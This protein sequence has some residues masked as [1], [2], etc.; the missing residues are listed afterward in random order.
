MADEWFYTQQGQ[1]Q[2]PVSAGQLKQLAISGR[3]LPTD[4]VWKEGMANWVPASSTRGLFPQSPASGAAAPA[5]ARAARSGSGPTSAR[6]PVTGA[7]PPSGRTAAPG[8][9]PISARSRS[10]PIHVT[11]IDE[12]EDED[13]SDYDEE[14]LEGPARFRSR[15]LST[16][17]WIAIIGGA[18]GVLVLV[19][20]VVLIIVLSS[21]GNN[22]ST[23]IIQPWQR[24]GRTVHFDAG[25]PV[26]INVT[27]DQN[28]DMDLEVYDVQNHL[29]AA[30]KSFGPNSH[31]RFVPVQSGDYRLDIVNRS[32]IANRSHVSFRQ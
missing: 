15:G 8:S 16:G 28:S 6:K 9:G 12:G 11:P 4:L 21:G 14:T 2:G 20:V 22:Y 26:E 29:V 5:S 17:A 10:G 27:S 7:A 24:N 32:A 19:V 1:Q 25:R 23:P 3:L 31:V 18:V 30:D 13:E